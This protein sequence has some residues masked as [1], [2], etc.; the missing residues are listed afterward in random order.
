MMATAARFSVAAVNTARYSV[1]KGSRCTVQ[2]GIAMVVAAGFRVEGL[3]ILNGLLRV[4]H[5]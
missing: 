2:S 5:D 1:P 4:K 3:L